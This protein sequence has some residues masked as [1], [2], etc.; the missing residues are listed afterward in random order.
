[1]LNS[2]FPRTHTTRRTVSGTSATS[3]YAAGSRADLG[4]SRVGSGG[5][6]L[7]RR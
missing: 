4:G 2:E 6:A 3:G 5:L 7:E 1:M